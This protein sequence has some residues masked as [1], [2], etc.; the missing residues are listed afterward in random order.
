MAARSAGVGSGVWSRNAGAWVIGAVSAALV[1]RIRPS[2]LFRAVMLITPL[3]LAIGLFSAGQ[4]GVHRWI[5]LGPLTWNV[6]FL[7]LPAAAVAFT[8]TTR[9]GL[10]WTLWAALAIQ[11]EL[12]LQPDASQAT[13]FAAAAI[14]AL[15]TTRSPSRN[16]IAATLFFGIAA[17]LAWFRPDPLSPVPEVEDIVK[18]A[19]AQSAAMA[20]FC[21]ASLAAVTAS[22]FW[23][24]N[25]ANRDTRPPAIALCAYFLICSLMRIFGPF[26]V[27]VVGMGMSPIIG[28]WL[29]IGALMSV[30]NS[31]ATRI[32]NP[33]GRNL[34]LSEGAMPQRS[35]II[36]S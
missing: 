19:A 23:G 21:I 22:P 12:C 31:A 35:P 4:S 1:A 6:A 10:R 3:A 27:P 13:A 33:P 16:P 30:C 36:H 28:F 34:H 15:G 24:S 14:A 25:H 26:P 11:V 18:L 8:A 7:L 9:S 29:G 2:T 20:A 5:V 17:V 32:D